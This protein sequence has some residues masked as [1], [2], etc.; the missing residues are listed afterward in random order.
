MSR[1][2]IPTVYGGTRFRSRLEA[3]WA[4]FFD[5]AGWAWEYEPIDLDGYIPD[6][7]LPFPAGALLVEVKPAFSLKELAPHTAKLERSGWE[8]EALIVGA[9]LLDGG[10]SNDDPV[11]GLLSQRAGDD[12]YWN[13]GDLIG[14]HECKHPSLYH[15]IMAW[16][17]YRCGAGGKVYRGDPPDFRAFWREAGNVTQ[18]RAA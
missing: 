6:F 3:R 1:N 2:G 17:C 5:Y 8:H 7:V 14:C 16:R 10:N 9:A 18:W 4:C 13:Q 12:W 15:P 11:V